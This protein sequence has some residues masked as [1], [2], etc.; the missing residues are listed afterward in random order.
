[1]TLHSGILQDC[2]INQLANVTSNSEGQTSDELPNLQEDLKALRLQCI[3]E[4]R[5]NMAE[6]RKSWQIFGSAQ[7]IFTDVFMALNELG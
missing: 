5:N 3:A 2:P 1:V 4:E 6:I 7:M